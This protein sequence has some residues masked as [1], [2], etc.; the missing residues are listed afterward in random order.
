MGRHSEYERNT[1]AS[2]MG[3][4]HKRCSRNVSC[5]IIIITVALINSAE[6]TENSSSVCFNLLGAQ[7]LGQRALFESP[8]GRGV[9]SS[10]LLGTCL[11]R[12]LA[13]LQSHLVSPKPLSNAGPLRFRSQHTPATGL[14]PK[15]SP[16]SYAGEMNAFTVLSCKASAVP[17]SPRLAVCLCSD[18]LCQGGRL[19]VSLLGDSA[20]VM[21]TTILEHPQRPFTF[22]ISSTPPQWPLFHP[23]GPTPHKA[24][25]D[26]P[27]KPRVTQMRSGTSE[28]CGDLFLG[29]LGWLSDTIL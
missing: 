12:H 21:V 27:W 29:I 23:L 8:Q 15:G 1:I 10:R 22:I 25:E 6:L 13:P 20:A 9:R 2:S 16:L 28:H 3:L 14:I 5:I 17:L 7:P 24:P 11:A 26:Q 19:C 18:L 4:S